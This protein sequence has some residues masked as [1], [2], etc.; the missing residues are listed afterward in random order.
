VRAAWWADRKYEMAKSRSRQVTG[1]LAELTGRTD[2]ELRLALTVAAVAG[3][4]FAG[5]RFVNFLADLGS[6]LRRS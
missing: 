4:L 1:T 5:L 2:D 6:R 3:A